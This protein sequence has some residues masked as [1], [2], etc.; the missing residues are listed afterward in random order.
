VWSASTYCVFGAGVGAPAAP[1]GVRFR[2]LDR[3]LELTFRLLDQ[4]ERLGAMA[5]EVVLGPLEVPGGDVQR[6]HRPVD[7]GM[8]LAPVRPRGL[9]LGEGVR[10]P[11]QHQPEGQERRHHRS[12]LP[13]ARLL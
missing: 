1:G 3:L 4:L 11:A 6:A 13:H 9:V 5:P 12:A 2:V 8:V 7:L 10:A